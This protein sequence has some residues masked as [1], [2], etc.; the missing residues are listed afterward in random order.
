MNRQTLCKA[1][2]KEKS[3]QKDDIPTCLKNLTYA[4]RHIFSAVLEASIS[5][6]CIEVAKMGYGLSVEMV[7]ELAFEVAEKNNLTMPKNW[8][9]NQRAGIDWFHGKQ[10]NHKYV[11]IL[12][13]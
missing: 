12:L 11:L 2:N 6:Y 1:V 4:H 13:I 9:T 3:N 7:R 8:I 10:L 5:S